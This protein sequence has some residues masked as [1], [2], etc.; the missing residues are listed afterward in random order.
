[1]RKSK[2]YR[3]KEKKRFLPERTH[4]S[5]CK[6][7]LKRHETLSR[8]TIITLNGAVYMTHIG[9]S[10]PN[11][12]CRECKKVYRSAR[13]DALALPNFTFGMDIIALVGYLKLSQHKTVD[14]VHKE[15]NERL[16]IHQVQMSR[17]NV[18]YLF[19]AYC[20][21]LKAAAKNTSDPMFHAWIEQ[22]RENK[23]CIISIDG[24][25]PDKGNETI[26]L[27]RDVKT[28]RLLH[29]QN[30][31]TSDTKTMK[32]VL[33]PILALN[34]PI[35]GFIS[36]AQQSIRDAIS[37]LWPDVPHQTCQFHYLQEAAR[38]IF[39]VDRATRKDMRKT[40]T[41][42]LRP[43]RSQIAKQVAELKEE[44]TEEAQREQE[45][46]Q[47][48]DDYVVAAKS[49]LNRDGNLPFDYPGLKGYQDLD[50]LEQSLEQI[51]KNR[52]K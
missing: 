8:K 36:D 10:C 18:M 48:I 4:C 15:V 42:K 13:A 35:S 50:V 5:T 29:A 23:D 17:R 20:A 26:Y 52:N 12:N 24:I 7:K 19:E 40:I 33:A 34:I 37:S 21:L 9:Y 22:I 47:I 51:K 39:E 43:L 45:Q 28:G 6:T 14:E 2:E 1:M 3:Q 11:E 44:E 30:V 46:L 25:Q 27:I 41:G 31:T 16:K 32:E 49:S 38:P